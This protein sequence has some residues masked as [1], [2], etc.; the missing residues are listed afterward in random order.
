M[1]APVPT[2]PR[3][4]PFR[5]RR[6]AA[7]LLVNEGAAAAKRLPES[8]TSAS[9]CFHSEVI[10]ASSTSLAA[11][12]RPEKRSRLQGDD[13]ARPAGSECSEVIGGARARATEVEPSES[14]CFGSVLESDLA[15][16]EKLADEAEATE[17]SSV[18]EPL[19]PLETEDEVL[20]RCSDYSLS[21]LLDLD[22][23]P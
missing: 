13:E 14:S 16:T 18:G 3:S 4:N 17:Y 22:S 8:S 1:L 7:P 12:Q 23:P 20:S 6:G 11:F 19:T 15:C 2:R 9:S 5:R 21:P 10:S